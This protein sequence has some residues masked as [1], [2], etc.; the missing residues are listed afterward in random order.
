MLQAKFKW[1]RQWQLH[2]TYVESFGGNPYDPAAMLEEQL[3]AR[4]RTGFIP[5]FVTPAIMENAVV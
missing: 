2:A 5:Y 1:T 4:K 3:R